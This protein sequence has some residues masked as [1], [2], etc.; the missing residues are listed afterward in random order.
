MQTVKNLQDKLLE[1]KHD[2]SDK[3]KKGKNGCWDGNKE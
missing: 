1:W 2:V 3:E